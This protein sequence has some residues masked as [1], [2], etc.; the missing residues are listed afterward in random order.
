MRRRDVIALLGGAAARPLAA[1]AQSKQLPKVGIL[2]STGAPG[3][4]TFVASMRNLGLIDGQTIM[5]KVGN[6]EIG[7]VRSSAAGIVRVRTPW[8][9]DA[10][11]WLTQ[12]KITRPERGVINAAMPCGLGLFEASMARIP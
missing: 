8:L 11:T 2:G 6:I 4:S 9:N 3:V 1:I 12:L 7:G 10:S 5:I